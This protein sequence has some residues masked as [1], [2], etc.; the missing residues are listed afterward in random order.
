[1]AV[2]SAIQNF[3]K[4]IAEQARSGDLDLVKSVSG[5][6]RNVVAEPSEPL[7]NTLVKYFTAPFLNLVLHYMSKMNEGK[8]DNFYTLDIFFTRHKYAKYLI[9]VLDGIC[10]FIILIV[11]GLVVLRGLG[12][13]KF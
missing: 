5:D 8:K 11:V 9:F 13:I 1:M 12:I 10:T 2:Q 7:I 3:Q 4:E 6:V